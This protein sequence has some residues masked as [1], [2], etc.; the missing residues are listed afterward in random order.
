MWVW[1]DQPDLPMS[2]RQVADYLGVSED[3][4]R[5]LFRTKRVPAFKAGGQWRVRQEDLMN[6]VIEQL[7]RT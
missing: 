5:H 6:F 1:P 4:A 3:V 7:Q 2:A